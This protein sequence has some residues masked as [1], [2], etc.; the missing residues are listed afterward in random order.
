MKKTYIHN[1]NDNMSLIEHLQELRERLF[2]VFVIF[3][4]ITSLS[5][6]SIKDIAYI[7]EKPAIHI[8]F[9]QLAP[10]EYFFVSIKIAIYFGV[11]FSIPFGIYQIIM[12]MLPGLTKQE[13]FYIIPILITSIILFF[14]GI[15]F[16]YQILIPAALN[17][18]INY[19]SDIVEPLWSFE[20]YFNFILILSFS[21]GITFQ[22]PILQILLGIFNIVTSNTMLK[23]WKYVVLGST[24]ISAVLT[25]STDPITQLFMS[26]AILSLYFCSICVLRVLKR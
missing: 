8:K 6:I 19:G 15:T 11:I 10:G 7:L 5:L 17:F 3:C 23:Y 14:L 13:A 26:L 4:I 2:I 20:E 18:F 1:N 9:L 25:P 22:I 16:A 12:F 21:T 24:I